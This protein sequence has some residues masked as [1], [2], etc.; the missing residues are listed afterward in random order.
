MKRYNVQ[1][2][3]VLNDEERLIGEISLKILID[4]FLSLCLAQE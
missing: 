4:K 1:I 2:L 3:A